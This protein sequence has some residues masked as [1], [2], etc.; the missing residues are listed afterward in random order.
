MTN[1]VEWSIDEY[2]AKGGFTSTTTIRIEACGSDDGSSRRSSRKTSSTVRRQRRKKLQQQQ[3]LWLTED[4]DGFF[5]EAPHLARHASSG[6]KARCSVKTPFSSSAAGAPYNKKLR[7]KNMQRQQHHRL[8]GGETATNVGADMGSSSFFISSTHRAV[9]EATTPWNNTSGP[10]AGRYH[11]FGQGGLPTSAPRP[12]PRGKRDDDDDDDDAPLAA[13]SRRRVLA[14][15][16][17][18]SCLLAPLRSPSVL[19]PLQL[20][21]ASR[22]EVSSDMLE[23]C[24]LET[25]LGDDDDFSLL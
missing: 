24:F 23:R 17:G 5:S 20:L 10:C 9:A 21:P 11:F 12:A 4:K 6:G 25:R 19:P 15:I 16:G 7:K 13:N 8:F 14:E 2:D 3:Q 22:A 18:S 1:C